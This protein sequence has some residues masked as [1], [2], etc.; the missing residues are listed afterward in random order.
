MKGPTFLKSSIKGFLT[1]QFCDL[2]IDNVQGTVKASTA[3]IQYDQ[4]VCGGLT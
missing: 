1:E 4:K 2:K 3:G